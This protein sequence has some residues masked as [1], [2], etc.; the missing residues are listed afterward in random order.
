M[1]DERRP[2][3]DQGSERKRRRRNAFGPNSA[4]AAV[5][6]RVA[7]TFFLRENLENIHNAV[8]QIMLSSEVPDDSTVGIDNRA[9]DV[10]PATSVNVRVVLEQSTDDL[11]EGPRDPETSGRPLVSM[12][13][14]QQ[15]EIS[16]SE[17][18]E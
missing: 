12:A 5:I 15:I 7:R 18:E 13:Q 2:G 16:D 17:E 11:I 8:E 4:E 1:E 3:Q 14:L 9:I 6:S 10:P